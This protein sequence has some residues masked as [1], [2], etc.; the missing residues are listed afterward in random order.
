M[1]GEFTFSR[2]K[3]LKSG[4]PPPPQKK[5]GGGE[6]LDLYELHETDKYSLG[7]TLRIT[8]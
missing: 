3:G 6:R 8:W 7:E 5:G 4:A 2:E 1:V